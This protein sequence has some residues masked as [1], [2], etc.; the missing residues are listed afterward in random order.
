MVKFP[1]RKRVFD[2]VGESHRN[3]D[4][5]SRQGVLKA[6]APGEEV[7]LVR[8]PN[9]PHGANAILVL[10]ETGK[11][12]GYISG[13]DSS[14]LAPVLDAGAIHQAH[15]HEL[16]GGGEGFE[17]LG[18]RICITWDGQERRPNKALRPEQDRFENAPSHLLHRDRR[19]SPSRASPISGRPKG[20]KSGGLLKAL[21][22]LLR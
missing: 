15:I 8:E 10:D 3:A 14:E 1:M 5:T 21:L 12:L 13:E 22:R 16:V 20:R 17:S 7:R 18:C 9:N 4:G 19:S 2:L 11:G 6:C